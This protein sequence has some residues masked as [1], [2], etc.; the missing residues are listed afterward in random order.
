MLVTY[1]GGEG[2]FVTTTSRKERNS[3]FVC[4]K[5]N[6]FVTDVECWLQY[7]VY[8]TKRS[9]Y[10]TEVL[11]DDLQF[12]MLCMKLTI[13]R[14]VSPILLITGLAAYRFSRLNRKSYGAFISSTVLTRT[15]ERAILYLAH[16]QDL[17]DV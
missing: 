9:I 4:I 14:R 11:S 16:K 7:G 2:K 6:C 15:K 3:R 5:L 12:K 17:F 1:H 10:N 8:I 13:L